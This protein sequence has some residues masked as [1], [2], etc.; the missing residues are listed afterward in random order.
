MNRRQFLSAAVAAG[1]TGSILRAGPADDQAAGFVTSEVGQL[2]RV[3]VHP[4]GPETRKAFPMLLGGHSMLTWELLRED[5][6]KQHEEFVKLLKQ[7][8]VEVLLMEELLEDAIT[9]ARKAG[10]L[11]DWLDKSVPQLAD[12]KKDLNAATLLGRDDRWIYRIDEAGI[13]RPAMLPATSLFFTRDLAVMMPRGVVLCGFNNRVRAFESILA[14]FAF[15]YSTPLRKYPIVFD[16]VKEQVHVQGGDVMVLD[17]NTLL[18]GVGNT[19]SEAAAI[20]L[21]KKLD[22]DVVAVQMPSGE[23][24]PGEWDGL[25]L[26]FYHLDCLLNLVDRRTVLAVPYLLEKEHVE[27][28]PLL[29]MLY[30]FARV[31]D[32]EKTEVSAMLAEVRN[33]GWIKRYKAGSGELDEKLGSMKILDYLKEQGF[34]AIYAGGDRPDGD[35]ELKHFNEHILRE[36]RFMGVNAVATQPGKIV[37]YAGNHLTTAALKKGGVD[38]TTFP[39]CE[40]VRANGGPH[41]LTLPLERMPLTGDDSR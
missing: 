6:T 13:F 2:K 41:C 28:N 3:V 32:V 15:Q 27:K 39:S 30:G 4:P 11:D 16:A 36:C 12:H 19:T 18:V 29:E 26:M 40:L 23:W 21:A 9:Q 20:S 17:A 37:S 24:Q 1:L 10:A 5:A 33:V 31:D 38:V 14:R 8:G 22:M 7:S 34:Q 35:N 25:Q